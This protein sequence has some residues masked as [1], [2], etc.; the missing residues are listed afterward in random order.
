[1]VQLLRAGSIFNPGLTKT[2]LASLPVTFTTQVVGTLD[3]AL[4]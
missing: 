2:I 3:L 4:P 1:M